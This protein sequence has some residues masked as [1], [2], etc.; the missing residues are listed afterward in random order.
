MD[1]GGMEK[2][3]RGT[4]SCIYERHEKIFDGHE[5]EEEAKNF[6]AGHF[7]IRHFTVMLPSHKHTYVGNTSSKQ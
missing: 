6:K 1:D 3:L 4:T 5:E 7:C 2:I